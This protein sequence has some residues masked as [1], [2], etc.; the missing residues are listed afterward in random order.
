MHTRD[1]PPHPVLWW[2]SSAFGHRCVDANTEVATK[3]WLSPDGNYQ[4]SRR[5]DSATVDLTSI[6]HTT[7]ST[8]TLTKIEGFPNPASLGRF[9]KN[10]SGK[11]QDSTRKP[12]SGV[13]Q[14]RYSPYVRITNIL[15]VK[16]ETFF[17]VPGGHATSPNRTQVRTTG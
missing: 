7:S 5:K 4:R 14:Q 17:R 1:Y 9:N 3:G 8:N 2:C 12:H 10:W 6:A 11:F 15:R 13:N 16:S